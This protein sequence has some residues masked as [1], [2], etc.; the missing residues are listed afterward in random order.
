MPKLN[1]EII[2]YN[3]KEAREQLEEIE[4]DIAQK[5]VLSEIEL[6]IKLEHA[7]HHLNFAWNIR[8]ESSK[9]YTHLTSS[10]FNKWSKFPKE[11]K[12][13]KLGKN[14]KLGKDKK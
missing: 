3:I 13:S 10:D 8:N 9:K 7:Y 4:N 12:P 2:L 1:R 6:Q 14:I 5:K 11:M